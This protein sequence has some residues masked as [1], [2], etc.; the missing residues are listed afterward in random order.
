MTP[1]DKLAALFAAQKPKSPDADFDMAVMTRVAR[2]RALMRFNR[3]AML[4]VVLG[5]LMMGLVAGAIQ[6]DWK[7]LSGLIVAMAAAGLA[8]LVVFSLRRAA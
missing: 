6:S 1:E 2:Y 4:V 5:G 8:G 3:Q 7:V